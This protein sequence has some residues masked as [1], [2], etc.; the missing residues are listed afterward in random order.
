[1]TDHELERVL[2]ALGRKL[3]EHC[4][5]IRQLPKSSNSPRRSESNTG[6]VEPRRAHVSK[7]A[8]CS[9]Q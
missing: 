4:D 1:M 8:S 7:K 9:T 2:Y 6:E 3:R 5:R